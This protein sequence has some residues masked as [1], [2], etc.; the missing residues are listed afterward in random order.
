ML[1]APYLREE[2]SAVVSAI[3][4]N[5]PQIVPDYYQLKLGNAEESEEERYAPIQENIL[6]LSR[7][8]QWRAIFEK[9]SPLGELRVQEYVSE[10][11]GVHPDYNKAK[12]R[13]AELLEYVL[14]SAKF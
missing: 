12:H 13:I 3:F 14:F 9:L 10:H 2:E 11:F 1:A 7:K 8:R 4:K 5:I 6:N